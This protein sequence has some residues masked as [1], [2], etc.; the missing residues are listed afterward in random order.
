MFFSH[1]LAFLFNSS[2]P[3]F[4]PLISWQEASIFQIPSD[5][6]PQVQTIISKY[7]QILDDQ[8]LSTNKQGI[9]IQSDWSILAEHQGKVPA[10]AASLTKIATTIASIDKWGLN[11]RFTTKIYGIGEINNGI[12]K[13]DLVVES[14]G[15]PL[16]VWEEAIILGNKLQQLGIIKVEGDLIVLGNWQMNYEEHS[17]K[18]GEL[19]KQA[20]NEKNWSGIIEKQYQKM[21]DKPIPP[22]IQIEGIVKKGDHIPDNAQLLLTH[23][24]LTLREILRAM[25]VYSNN[26]IAESLAQQIG[27]GEKVGDIAS[28]I[29]NVPQEEILLENGSGLGVDNRISPRGVCRMLM[30]LDNQ[31]DS[32]GINLGDLFPVAGVDKKGTVE[33]R[34]IPYGIPTKTGTLSVVSALAGVIPTVQ[35]NHVYFAVINYGSD[36]EDLRKKQDILLR[37]LEQHWTFKPLLPTKSIDISFGENRLL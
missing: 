3:K 17:L 1:L 37:N 35:R 23:Q 34:N 26:K 7:L 14:G 10:P 12:L 31:L 4:L 9:W 19:L 11:Y 29:A 6:D 21:K 22:K 20:L 2:Q 15:D 8:G 30:A 33:Y 18:S 27:G 16:F 5:P 25:N 24:S 32:S 13:G 36:I 28:K